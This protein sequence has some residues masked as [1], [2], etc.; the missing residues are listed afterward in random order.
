MLG[1]T[2][3][4]QL[5]LD[6]LPVLYALWNKIVC[7]S[8]AGDHVLQSILCRK[9][10]CDDD[11]GPL[12]NLHLTCSQPGVHHPDQAPGGFEKVIRGIEASHVL[13]RQRGGLA[14][15]E[16]LACHLRILMQGQ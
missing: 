4:Y 3:S 15:R 10:C 5:A 7:I 14:G 11:A 9:D 6:W 8:L 12:Q 16:E 1:R 13:S 2:L